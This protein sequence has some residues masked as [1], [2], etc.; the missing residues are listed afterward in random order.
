MTNK[1]LICYFDILGF[2][3]LVDNNSHE[4]L[5]QIY[6]NHLPDMLKLAL[7]YGKMQIKEIEN[8]K[9]WSPD[10]QSFNLNS[11]IVSDSIILWSDELN[12]NKIVDILAVCKEFIHNMIVIGLPVRAAITI[13][14][15]DKIENAF[16]SFM[17]NKQV[18]ILGKGLVDAY[19]MEGN[20]EWAGGI[21]S[22]NVIKFLNE[23]FEKIPATDDEGFN[24]L[25]YLIE[26]NIIIKYPPP[27]KKSMDIDFCFN[28]ALS[29]DKDHC[30]DEKM[31]EGY[32]KSFKKQ[33]DHA[34]VQIK[35][36]NTIEFIRHIKILNGIA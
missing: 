10:F 31:I 8:K 30:V 32:F 22:N 33:V 2:K 13:G 6:N 21:V 19:L 35:I 16:P 28:W 14:E 23:E 27:L 26:K 3:E 18:S 24:L 5:L 9:I 17:D 36:N 34:S 7:G 4:E 29:P 20:Q 12:I 1:K 11:L 15:F 25:N